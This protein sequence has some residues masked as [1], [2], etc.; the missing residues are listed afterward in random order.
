MDIEKLHEIFKKIYGENSESTFF[1]PGR[2][3]LI[4]EHIDYNGG[5][6]FPCALDLGTYGLIKVRNDNKINFASTNFDLKVSSD[7]NNLK[8]NAQD[9]WAN[10]P[11]GVIKIMLDHG[12]NAQGMDILISGNI[13]NGAGL[14]SSASLEVL[15]GEI[16]NTLFNNSR[17]DMIDIVK[18]SQKSENDYVGVNCGIMDQ[19]AIGMGKKAKAILLNCRTLEYAYADVNL[20]GYEIVIM[21]TNKR[22]ALN[23]SKYNERRSECEKALAIIKKVKD[24]KNICE[25]KPEEFDKIENLFTD[26]KI[27]NRAKH[28]VYENAR[29]INAFN[30]LNSGHLI[31]FGRLL[32]ESH[33]SLKHLYEVTGKELDAIVE[34]ALLT[35]GC[36][37]ARMT[38]AGFGGCAIALV[39]KDKIELFTSRVKEKYTNRIG[40]APTF[41]STGIG[42][43]T[44]RVE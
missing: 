27:K 22:R 11:K 26:E 41:Y 14:S 16:I 37:G 23:E 21:N 43:G 2:I 19:F 33:H 20:L 12:Y 18:M 32:M 38:G 4:G 17:I 1:S 30:C 9:D 40:Y 36:I 35:D 10:Y 6:V 28:S 34:E 29:V 42:E 25:L 7:L 3:N 24:I 44:H 13:P 5:F 15:T 39:K 31:E 8:Y